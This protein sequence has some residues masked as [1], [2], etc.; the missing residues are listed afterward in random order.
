MSEK[1]SPQP[2]E[3]P[4]LITPVEHVLGGGSFR[5]Q[6][7]GCPTGLNDILPRPRPVRKVVPGKED[8]P[9]QE[10]SPPSPPGQP[11]P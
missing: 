3:E 4:T 10:A 6:V 8:P 1:P 7:A 5:G 11:K 9:G 2:P